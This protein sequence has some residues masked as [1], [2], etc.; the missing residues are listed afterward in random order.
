M[1]D[2]STPC[3]LS[4]F[5]L[6]AGLDSRCSNEP[7]FRGVGFTA[8]VAP[9]ISARRIP[10]GGNGRAEKACVSSVR[11]TAPNPLNIRSQPVSCQPL[12]IFFSSRLGRL[13]MAERQR[14]RNHANGCAGCRSGPGCDTSPGPPG[15]KSSPAPA[16]EPRLAAASRAR[17]TAGSQIARERRA[18][19]HPLAR[20]TD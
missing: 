18:P 14:E 2:L 7:T 13:K 11:R 3:L 19:P 4:F 16:Y 8:G 15:R 6:R 12:A 1:Q 10:A 5:R 9:T 20:T 17:R